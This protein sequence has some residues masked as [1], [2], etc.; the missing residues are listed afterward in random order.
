M[1]K[2]T[3]NRI[4]SLTVHPTESKLLIAAGEKWGDVGIWDA[5]DYTS[6]THG[7]HLFSVRYFMMI[8]FTNLMSATIGAP[9]SLSKNI[10]YFSLIAV[11]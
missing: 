3:P 8:H 7:V 10:H 4:F 2:V 9:N 6:E 5:N 1:A 11:Q